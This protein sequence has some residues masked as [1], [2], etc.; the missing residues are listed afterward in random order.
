MKIR[1]KFEGLDE[2]LSTLSPQFS[3][4]SLN[5]TNSYELWLNENDLDGLPQMIKDGAK[6][7]AKSK[8]G[9][10]NGYLLFSSQ[11]IILL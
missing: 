11:V 3:N 9:K 2:E 10:M 8:E 5:A 4:N 6:M 1:I 7:A